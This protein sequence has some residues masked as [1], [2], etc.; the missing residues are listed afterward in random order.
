[1]EKGGVLIVNKPKKILCTKIVEK[2]RKRF[3][4][5]VGHTGVIDY[6]G[7]GVLILLI[8]VATKTSNLFMNLDKE[9]EFTAI[10]G[11]KT[12]TMDITG[13]VIL[14]KDVS[15][16]EE[17]KLIKVA[18]EF[19]GKLR[20]KVPPFSNKKYSGEELYKLARQNREVPQLYTQ[21]EIY[22][23]TPIKINMP[24]FTF[25]VKCSKGTYI[26]SL[27]DEIGERIGCGAT[28][29]EL[30]RIAVGNFRIEEAIEFN[31][32]LEIDESEFWNLVISLNDAL[33]FLPEIEIKPDNIF[34]FKNGGTLF[35]NH[36]YS[37]L[38][39]GLVKV[40]LMDEL[41]G[42]GKVLLINGRAYLKPERVLI[43]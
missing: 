40:T 38:Q 18:N 16:I 13:N 19:V 37:N 39:E 17:S 14:E 43:K 34:L 29:V 36:R 10:L 6:I 25:R 5:K 2:V 28:V 35:L 23:L 22:E 9:Y 42:I 3:K 4:V 1:M 32:L 7:S 31:K 21:V 8:E 27:V 15:D 12:D 41:I 26:R 33:Y 30:E 11:K 20:L 24:Y